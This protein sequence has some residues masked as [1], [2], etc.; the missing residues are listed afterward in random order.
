M[1][2]TYSAWAAILLAS[3]LTL[4]ESV[5]AWN[6]KPKAIKRMPTSRNRHDEIVTYA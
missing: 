5:S 4:A 6:L 3:A 2:D 1:P